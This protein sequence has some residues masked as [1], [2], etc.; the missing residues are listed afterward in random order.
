M[1]RN[2]LLTTIGLL[3]MV[4]SALLTDDRGS[5]W[6]TRSAGRFRSSWRR[7]TARRSAMVGRESLRRSLT[8]LWCAASAETSCVSLRIAPWTHSAA[9]RTASEGATPSAPT[10]SR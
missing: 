5:R 7:L 9:R 6:S 4:A 3:P 10:V 2:V 8:R 1:R